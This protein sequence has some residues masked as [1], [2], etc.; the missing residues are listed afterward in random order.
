MSLWCTLFAT[1]QAPDLSYGVKNK[2]AYPSKIVTNPITGQSI[3]FIQTGR[4]TQGL[5]LEMESTYQPHST[6]P[7]PHFHP[8]QE[9]HFKVLSG[10]IHVRLNGELKVL[11]VGDTLNVPHNQVHS[12]WNPSEEKAVVNWQVQP[13]LDTEYFLE[14]GMGLAQAGKVKAD[15]MPNL[16]QSVV[17]VTR[18]K[19]VYRLAKPGPMVQ[20]IV[21]SILAPLAR[22]MGYRAVYKEYLD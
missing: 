17:L 11:N 1:N 4:D 19:N 16:L 22:L 15:G 3:K 9:E 20:K 13:A 18:F 6:E 5:L 12:M 7:M 2:M 8:K 14:I 10:S 21:F